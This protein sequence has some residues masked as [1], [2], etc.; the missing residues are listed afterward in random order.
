MTPSDLKEQ[1]I[2]DNKIIDVLKALHMNHI[3]ENTE[4]ISC[5]MPDGDNQKSTIIYKDNL[6]VS[7]Y[8]RDISDIYGG[9]DII[10]LVMYVKAPIY[11]TD[12]LRWICGV[13]DYDFYG[14]VEDKPEILSIFNEI[15]EMR[16]CDSFEEEVLNSK[17]IDEYLLTYLQPL[18]SKL[19]LD[20][21]ISIKTQK[22]FDIRYDGYD[23][24]I[25]IPIRDEAGILVGLKGR[26]NRTKLN[27][28]ENKY[29][30]LTECNKSSILFGL[31]LAY[32]EIKRLGIVYVTEAEK[33]VMQGFSAGV[34]NVVAIGGKKLSRAQVRKLTYLGVEICL[35]YDDGA[36]IGAKGEVDETFYKKQ[37]N[38]FLD[39]VKVSHI[40]DPRNKIIAD[41]ESPFDRM[42][43]WDEL[44][45]LKKYI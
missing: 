35:C 14:E 5:G 7:A 13:C 17:P 3:R 21:G 39:A 41:K 12:A 40:T 37:K 31:N 2:Y 10:S 45:K 33:G 15:F 28:F 11:F 38:M 9:S 8:T 44:L 27:S 34:K 36:D 24:R 18:K 29:M 30:Y 23:N 4:H 1:I 42:D 32:D 16:S 25:V 22:L 20:D 19:F 43:K 6:N 26:L